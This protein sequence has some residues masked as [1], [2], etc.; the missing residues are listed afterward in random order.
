MPFSD[1]GPSSGPCYAS[2]VV[3]STA[4]TYGD[5]GAGR[6]GQGTKPGL[7]LALCL[8][9]NKQNNDPSKTLK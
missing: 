4:G 2:S 3:G 7:G 5:Q 1:A 8:G 6:P 9:Q